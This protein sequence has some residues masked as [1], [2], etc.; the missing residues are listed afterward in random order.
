MRNNKLIFM[1]LVLL[2]SLL[3]ISAVSAADDADLSDI[4]ADTDSNDVAVL[5]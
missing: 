2:V 1:A 3:C 4:V 5:E